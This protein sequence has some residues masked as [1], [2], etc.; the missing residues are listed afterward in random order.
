[1]DF[2]G[3]KLHFTFQI[4]VSG[5]QKSH[6]KVVVNA[7]DGK[8][9]FRMVCNDLVRRLALIDQRSDDLIL[10]VE[11][12]SGH[13]DSGPGI[14][15]TLP[16]FPISEPGI[17][18]IFVGN[19]TMIDLFTASIADV[20]SPIKFAAAFFLKIRTG[21]V[22]GGTGSTFNAAKKD[23]I[24]GIR[25]LTAETLGTEVLRIK[26]SPF[27]K[28]IG[29]S[30]RSRVLTEKAGNIFKGCTLI[31]FILDIDTILYGEMLLVAW[32]IFTHSQTPST[33]V[34]RTIKV[35]YQYA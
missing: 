33:A 21:L 22:T 10:F 20:G 9:Q 17:V 24:A 8:I 13:S 34:R 2:S 27:V 4:N 16:V 32:D 29:G 3:F 35:S 18:G 23:L 15:E 6:I 14:L 30:S 26:K 11:F 5:S 19:R 12:L 31:Q 7:A 28:P 25:F 1:M